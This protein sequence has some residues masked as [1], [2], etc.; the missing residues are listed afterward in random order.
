MFL[1]TY[2]L[3]RRQISL[4]L[5]RAMYFRTVVAVR[6]LSASSWLRPAERLPADTGLGR[7]ASDTSAP[8]PSGLCELRPDNQ[9]HVQDLCR[10]QAVSHQQANIRRHD[11]GDHLLRAA[12]YVRK[13]DWFIVQWSTTGCKGC[14]NNTNIHPHS[15]Q[16]RKKY[17]Y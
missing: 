4:Q 12:K 7:S 3:T 8:V 13:D 9:R 5:Q 6:W 1:L 17:Q 15:P 14:T 11:Q 10:K 2:L 16:K